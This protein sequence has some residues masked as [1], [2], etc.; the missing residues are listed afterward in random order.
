MSE[1]NSYFEFAR[2][3]YITKYSMPRIHFA[4]LFLIMLCLILSLYTIIQEINRK[5]IEKKYPLVVY[6]ND[7]IN[8][9]SKV[10]S[11]GEESH[12]VDTSIAKYLIKL[13]VTERESYDHRNI[14][15]EKWYN[16]FTQI[17]NMSSRQ[18][19]SKYIQKIDPK[20]NSNS[21]VVNYGNSISRVIKGFRVVFPKNT[22]RPSSADVQIDIEEQDNYQKQIKSYK[23]NIKINFGMSDIAQVLD[24]KSDLN[25]VITSYESNIL[26]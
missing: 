11:I 4:Y 15:K 10:V 21:P 5:Y 23:Q 22:V 2:K 14:G 20:I 26:E 24:G 9:F 7:Q 3:W 25:F 18:I 1:G 8:Y 6:T 19:F 16:H 17:K 13:Y 12:S